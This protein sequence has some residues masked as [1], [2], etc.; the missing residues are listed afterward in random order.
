MAS[1]GERRTASEMSRLYLEKY[2]LMTDAAAFSS[3]ALSDALL[4]AL[5]YSVC[6]PDRETMSLAIWASSSLVRFSLIPRRIGC[7]MAISLYLL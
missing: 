4:S 7:R 3:L 1:S 2:L 6:C 5:S